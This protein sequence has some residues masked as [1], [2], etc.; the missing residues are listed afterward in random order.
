MRTICKI[1]LERNPT[2][3]MPWNVQL[4]H[5]FDGGRSFV[6]SGFGRFFTD[7]SEGDRA[8]RE[9][10]EANRSPIRVFPLITPERQKGFEAASLE[11]TF[12]P[13]GL[14]LYRSRWAMKEVPDICG[15]Y[16]RACRQMNDDE[17]ANRALCM[18]C[19]LT[20]YA[21]AVELMDYAKGE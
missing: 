9:Y 10:A 11:G 20:E 15:Y 1:R 12:A 14:P 5:S 7:D 4:W 17:G 3:D 21:H 6:Y 8:M 18:G 19:P 2:G 13:A 16:G